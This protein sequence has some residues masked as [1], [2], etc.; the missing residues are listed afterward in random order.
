LSLRITWIQPV[1]P[2]STTTTTSR[3][4]VLLFKMFIEPLLEF[5]IGWYCNYISLRLK[6]HVYAYHYSP[7]LLAYWHLLSS[8]GVFWTEPST[9]QYV[10]DVY[11]RP[12]HFL[13]FN[14][15]R[16]T[17][18]YDNTHSFKHILH[19]TKLQKQKN[20]PTT[21]NMKLTLALCAVILAATANAAAMPDADPF[22]HRV[23]EPCSK[24][25]RA[26]AA[27]A[28]C[29][30]VGEP[31]S[32]VKRAAEAVAEAFAEPKADASA[33]AIA[34][35]FCHRVGEPCSKAKRAAD[36]L[37][38][39]VAEAQP[40]PVAF[41]EALQL[42][43]AFP[44]ADASADAGM[45]LILPPTPTPNQFLETY[46]N[47]DTVDAE[48]FCH[49]VGEPCSKVRRDA[50]AFCH[51]VGE[52]CSKV[53]R[54]AE[55]VALAFAEP[56]ANPEP[57][58]HRVGEPCSKTKREAEAFCHRVGEPCSKAKRDANAEAE[59]FCHRVGEPCSKA[60]RDASALANAA[61]EALASL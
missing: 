12:S 32:K 51:R 13:H 21:F 60:K 16:I 31:C 33:D 36:A 18:L 49:R 57:F 22:C 28:F 54:A 24:V 38:A 9:E 52:P 58:C 48:A 53:K 45:S 5:S 15:H 55:A 11:K 37:A 26:A 40:N 2:A 41:Y 17:L 20:Q 27:E 44:T 25:K 61:A 29:H 34:E 43:D 59:A 47:S 10:L 1:C 6:S 19:K 23:G 39:A 7:I 8:F 56:M 50:E 4:L 30:R 3:T 42:R 14:L 46:A 35:A